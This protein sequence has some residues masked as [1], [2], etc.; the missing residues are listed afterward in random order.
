MAKFIKYFSLETT[1]LKHISLSGPC[2]R[3]VDVEFPLVNCM[4]RNSTIV[5]TQQQRES[6]KFSCD[7][8][9]QEL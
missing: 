1:G 4:S 3:I 9:K 6:D 2:H 7:C 8:G 5:E